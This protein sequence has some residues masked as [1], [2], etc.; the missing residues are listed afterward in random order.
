MSSVAVLGGSG[1]V[2]GVFR[3]AL[4][5]RG[6]EHVS[7]SRAETRYDD[8]SALVAL[9]ERD[10]PRFLINAAGFTGK[11]NVDA[12]EDA[13]GE[14]LRGNVLLPQTVAH[15]CQVTGTPWGH[16]SSGCIYS[17]AK[18]SDGSVAKDLLAPEAQRR[19]EAGAK[20]LGYDETDPPNFSFDDPPCSFYS[21]SKA[22]GERALTG[23]PAVYVWRMRLPFDEHHGPRNLLSKL[24]SYPKLYQNL[25]SLSHLGHFVEACLELWLGGAPFGT[26]NLT[27]PGFVRTPEIARLSQQKLV[28]GR[29]PEFWESDEAF[30][31]K[32]VRALR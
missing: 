20:I 21:G 22:L 13:R 27:N 26:Y 19:I 4:T 12:C 23:A 16:V 31:S 5:R 7:W 1:W 24:L 32:G 11:P 6:V 18:L 29:E 30:Y 25:N 8:F 17:G 28:P 2:G 14:T 10:K 9:L 3:R 15:A